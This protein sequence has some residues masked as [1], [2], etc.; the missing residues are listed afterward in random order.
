MRFSAF[1]SESEEK[2]ETERMQRIKIA[3]LALTDFD[4]ENISFRTSDVSKAVSKR[5]AVADSGSD[6]IRAQTQS[7]AFR[8]SSVT[9]ID[10]NDVVSTA[11]SVSFSEPIKRVVQISESDN[12]GLH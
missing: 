11:I 7:G 2:A 3:S 1:A 12:G 6:L 4:P 10:G 5:Y 8:S 9:A